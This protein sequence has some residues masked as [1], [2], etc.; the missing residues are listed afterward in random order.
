MYIHVCVP[1]CR[2]QRLMSDVFLD[3][4]SPYKSRYGLSVE[5]RVSLA[6]L[7]AP[8]IPSLPPMCWDDRRVIMPH[9]HLMW[10][11]VV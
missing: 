7:L 8:G 6:S 1:V 2:G 4:S 10:V 5:P 3:H 9:Q 11:L